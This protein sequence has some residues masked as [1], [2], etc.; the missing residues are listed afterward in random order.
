LLQKDSLD[1]PQLKEYLG[2]IILRIAQ[3]F[4][5]D[6]IDEKMQKLLESLNNYSDLKENSQIGSV[7]KNSLL[8]TLFPQRAADSK[9]MT[10]KYSF[11]IFLD[12]I[13]KIQTKDYKS[14]NG[15]SEKFFLSFRLSRFLHNSKER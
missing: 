1:D 11:N 14:N 8:N 10:S 13:L 6:L 2:W 12:K 3:E 5:I 4:Q 15:K 7:Q 9:S